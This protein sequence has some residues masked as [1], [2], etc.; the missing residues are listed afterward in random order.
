MIRAALIFGALAFSGA[1]AHSEEIDI[2]G[3][4]NFSANL[5]I[6]CEFSGQATLKPA[7]DKT[8]SDYSCEMT[9][10]QYCP[11]LGIDYAVRQSCKVR[12]TRG[13]VWV[14]ATI[15]EFLKGEDTGN[16][17]PD[18]FNLS[19]QSN[20]EMTGALIS[21]GNARPA[22]WIRTDGTIS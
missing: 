12:N 8:V 6:P 9:A 22:V 15:K 19:V 1:L 13:Q 4:W 17:Y 14:Q 11:S 16:Y 10:R 2:T 21:S 5:R 20:S 3:T 7:D 18:N